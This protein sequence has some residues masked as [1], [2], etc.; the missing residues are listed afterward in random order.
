MING[1]KQDAVIT[2]GYF[3]VNRKWNKG[4]KVEVN[5]PMG[6]REVVASEKIAED[7]NKIAL[8]YG[9]LVYAVEEAD[10]ADVDSI[11]VNSKTSLKVKAEP[12]LLHGVHVIQG[13]NDEKKFT[14]IPYYSW[15]NRGIGKMKVW[16]PKKE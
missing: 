6:I 11:T 7:Q 12:D 1:K 13:S 8:E 15:S 10:N 2:N 16:L 9:P 14:A 3:V 4:D 5:F